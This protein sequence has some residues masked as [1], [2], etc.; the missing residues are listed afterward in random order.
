LLLFFD[1]RE[2]FFERKRKNERVGSFFLLGKKREERVSPGTQKRRAILHNYTH[3]KH[4][5]A[6]L[7][8][9]FTRSRGRERER[10]RE[11]ACVCVSLA[12]SE[13][14]VCSR[15]RRRRRRRRGGEKAR[16]LSLSRENLENNIN[17]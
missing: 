3:T 14:F 16:S 11:C 17:I 6:L 7:F 2:A 4:T 10:E 9:F 15:G 8:F 13:S 12:E 5:N 1:E